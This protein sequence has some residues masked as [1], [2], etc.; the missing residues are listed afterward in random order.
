MGYDCLKCERE[1]KKVRY[2]AGSMYNKEQFMSQRAGDFYCDKCEG[3]RG[4]TGY[5]YYWEHELKSER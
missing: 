1:L 5:R 2:P 4:N 3:D